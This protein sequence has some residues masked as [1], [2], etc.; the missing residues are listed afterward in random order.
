MNWLQTAKDSF[1][2]R[3]GDLRYE[4]HADYLEFEAQTA[5]LI[6]IAESIHALRDL[7]RTEDGGLA[8]AAITNLK[9]EKDALLTL[10]KQVLHAIEDGQVTDKFI[11]D[12]WSALIKWE[13][14]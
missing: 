14:E 12:A 13:R 3:G 10:T 9:Q 4:G 5:A 1:H 6:A 8:A 11:D 7:L 2:K